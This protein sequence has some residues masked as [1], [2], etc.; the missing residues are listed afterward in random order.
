MALISDVSAIEALFTT[1][2]VCWRDPDSGEWSSHVGDRFSSTKFEFDVTLETT[3]EKIDDRTFKITSTATITNQKAGK[4]VRWP[5]LRWPIP[6]D[7]GAYNRTV[8]TSIWRDGP[9]WHRSRSPLFT[10]GALDYRGIDQGGSNYSAPCCALDDGYNTIGLMVLDSGPVH[11][12]LYQPIL[13]VNFATDKTAAASTG[14][15]PDEV[16]APGETKTMTYVCNVVP[17]AGLA[18]SLEAVK[19]F[20]DWFKTQFPSVGRGPSLAG[21]RWVAAFW[22]YDGLLANRRYKAYGATGAP[23][24][25]FLRADQ[26]TSMYRMLDRQMHYHVAGVQSEWN[27]IAAA[28]TLR[29]RGVTG[30]LV[31]T[32]SGSN[33]ATGDYKPNVVTALPSALAETIAQVKQ[34]E[35]DRGIKAGLYFGYGLSHVSDNPDDWDSV[36]HSAV[37]S[38]VYTPNTWPTS[39]DTPPDAQ[40]LEAGA[41]DF[42]DANVG[43]A[44]EFF[45]IVGIDAGQ[46]AARY[47]YFQE[48]VQ[49]YR[50]MYPSKILFVEPHQSMRTHRDAQAY[51]NAFPKSRSH[52]W[53][54]VYGP[55]GG[56]GV[57][58]FN[59][60][61]STTV[62]NRRVA[63]LEAMGLVPLGFW[64]QGDFA[65]APAKASPTYANALVD[66]TR[67]PLPGDDPDNGGISVSQ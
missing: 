16:F 24:G 48:A 61:G 15:R 32:A 57:V 51:F 43:A 49:R 63:A 8:P 3:V 33:P 13:G 58:P 14:I 18:K 35:S 25:D 38:G 67:G 40:A 31:W 47:P 39:S 1:D 27:P 9:G 65:N 17:G 34:W 64:D 66:L 12:G 37:E 42:W 62:R 11:I 7:P 22:G 52:L 4:Y 46:D 30:M 23:G 21:E 56:D 55:G 59:L 19:P 60:D 54:V 28:S 5:R 41:Y 6:V 26:E 2:R 29:A 45:S 53:D 50:E 20:T 44:L 10:H 36:H